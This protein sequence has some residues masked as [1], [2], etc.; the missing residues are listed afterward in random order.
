MDTEAN[1]TEG[2][3]RSYVTVKVLSRKLRG[4]L[5]RNHKVA[6]SR[7]S[8]SGSTLERGNFF[9]RLTQGKQQ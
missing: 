1:V 4:E 8:V 3:W 6:Q 2:S 5:E 7:Q 9:T